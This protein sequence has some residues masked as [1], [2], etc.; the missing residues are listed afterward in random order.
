MPADSPDSELSISLQG[1]LLLASPTLG[2]GTFD[3]SVIMLA[4]HSATDGAF[5]MIINHPTDAS[6]GD[7]VPD[8]GSSALSALP[9][10]R[11]GPLSTDELT[12]SSFAWS[13]KNG[14][15]YLPNISAKV[16]ASMVGKNGH[17]VQATVGHSAWSPGQLENELLRNT[18]I[19]L[20]PT[21]SLLSQ[22]HDP[23]L[24]KS[25]LKTISPYHDLLSQAPRNPLIN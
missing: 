18:W 20:R 14:L 10:H 19:T 3:H 11:G 17:I 9:V 4:Q 22:P 13:G 12:F 2:D 15:A 8:L 5:G 21:Q 24:W 25:L 7:L 1:Q 23:A 6:V 16:A